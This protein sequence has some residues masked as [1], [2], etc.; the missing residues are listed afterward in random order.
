[1][2]TKKVTKGLKRQEEACQNRGKYVNKF[3][4]SILNNAKNCVENTSGASYDATD[5]TTSA[6]TSDTTSAAGT[7]SR[8]ICMVLAQLL[9]YQ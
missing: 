6:T 9:C 1:M 4:E 3:T 2:D 5:A 8:P 7:T